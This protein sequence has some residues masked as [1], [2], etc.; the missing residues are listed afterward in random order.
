MLLKAHILSIASLFP[1]LFLYYSF[2][3][4]IMFFHFSLTLEG[5]LSNTENKCGE[6]KVMVYTISCI[7]LRTMASQPHHFGKVFKVSFL[8]KWDHITFPE[9]KVHRTFVTNFNKNKCY[10]ETPHFTMRG[11]VSCVQQYPVK[12]LSVS[13]FF[14]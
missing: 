3:C 2:L 13:K 10:Q 6:F 5:S 14:L 1:S 4:V 12:Y 11:L 7:V 8:F 9:N